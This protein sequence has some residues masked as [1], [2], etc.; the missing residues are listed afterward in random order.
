VCR[1]GGGQ[2]GNVGKKYLSTL[3]SKKLS[4]MPWITKLTLTLRFC[5]LARNLQNIAPLFSRSSLLTKT[6]AHCSNRILQFD[7]VIREH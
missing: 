2:G 6:L 5:G 3:V 4:K 7:G 1:G